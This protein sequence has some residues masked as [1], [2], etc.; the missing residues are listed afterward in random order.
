M[1]A[2]VTSLTPLQVEQICRLRVLLESYAVQLVGEQGDREDIQRLEARMGDD[3]RRF[4]LSRLVFPVF[5]L[6]TR[7]LVPRLSREAWL[8][9]VEEHSRVVDSLRAGDIPG[10]RRNLKTMIDGF[11][12]Q[13]R[14]VS[15]SAP[16]AADHAGA[17]R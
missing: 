16:P 3:L 15:A 11:G 13:T 9:N 12:G 5:A 8:H 4:F 14:D 2:C 17:L 10:A 6:K 1:G 7:N